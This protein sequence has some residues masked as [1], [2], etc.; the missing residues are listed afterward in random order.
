MLADVNRLPIIIIPLKM[1]ELRELAFFAVGTGQLPA[2]LLLAFFEFRIDSDILERRRR[3]QQ[4]LPVVESR[5]T[6]PRQQ[7]R[8]AFLGHVPPVEF[9]THEIADRP[10]RKLRG[11]IAAADGQVS[12]GECFVQDRIR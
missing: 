11:T 10:G 9:I 8:G 2:V 5:L 7:K 1:F 6:L 3:T 4:F 12:P